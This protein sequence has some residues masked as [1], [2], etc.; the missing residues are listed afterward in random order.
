V[1]TQSISAG[2]ESG[3]EGGYDSALVSPPVCTF[4]LTRE[5]GAGS[6]GSV[7]SA[8]LTSPCAGH[9]AGTGVAV[10]YLHPELSTDERACA[11][12][13]AEARVGRTLSCRGLVT[14][15]GEGSDDRGR[16]LVME[17]VEG[18]T[19]R[20]RL[21]SEALVEE[22]DVRRI[23]RRLASVLAELHAAGFRH[24]DVKPENIRL[25]KEGEAVLLDLG[26]A[27]GEDETA[28]ARGSL[29]YL[30][31]EQ[32][33]G[34]PSTP[35]SDVFSLGLVLYELATGEHPFLYGGR[36]PTRIGPEDA[37][38]L[39]ASLRAARSDLASQR[40][41]QLSPFLDH[42]LDSLLERRPDHRPTARELEQRLEAGEAGEWWRVR[43]HLAVTQRR[44]RVDW[45]GNSF[46]PLVGRAVELEKL[47]DVAARVGAGSGTSVWLAGPPGVG[48]SRLVEEFVLRARASDRPPLHLH[49]R[50]NEWHEERPAQPVISLLRQWL[51]LP[52]RTAPGEREQA[53]LEA[54]LPP[55]TAATLASVLDPAFEGATET[56]IPHALAEWLIALG[57]EQPAIVF[58]DDIGWAGPGTIK[59]LEHIATDLGAA[60]L[61]LVFGL[62]QGSAPHHAD[63]LD[64][65]RKRFEAQGLLVA[66]Q[67]AP[68]GEAAV[69]E[70]VEEL[71]HHSVPRLPLARELWKRTRGN[72]G[73]LDELLRS[74]VSRGDAYPGPDPDQ[75]LLLRIS[76]ADLPLPKSLPK[77]I[78]ERY[79]ALPP[80]LRRWLRRL[81]IMGGRIE[82]DFLLEA[83]PETP[84][85]EIEDVLGRLVRAEWIIPVGPR[86]R[87]ARPVLR[88]AVYRSISEERRRRLHGIAARTLGA[89][90]ARRI[91][92]ASAFQRA[93]HL[94]AAGD[95]EELL[96][97]VRPLVRGLLK[98][99]HPQRVDSL[100]RWGLEAINSLPSTK[101]HESLRVQ[102]LEAAVDAADRLGKRGHQRGLLDRLS[103]LDLSQDPIAAGRVYLLHGRYA[104]STGQYGAARGMLHNALTFFERGKDETHQSEAL[105]RQALLFSHVGEMGDAARMAHRALHLATSD[106]QR[107]RSHLALAIIDLLGN[108]FAD[109]LRHSDRAQKVLRGLDAADSHGARAAA[110]LVR[111]RIYRQLGRPRRA[112]GALQRAG[113]HAQLSGERWL[114]AEVTARVGGLLLDLGRETEAEERL[115]EAL[116]LASE[117]ED[118]R[119]EALASVFL[120]TLLGEN[121]D[122]EARR[123]LERATRL[124]EE[125]GLNRLEA[126][127]LA[128]R[129]RLSRQDGDLEQALAF[130]KRATELLER[131]GAEFADRVVID[132]TRALI[133]REQGD[134]S[135]ARDLRKALERT[136]KRENERLPSV[137]LR[138]R[139]HRATSALLEASLS[140]DGP[141]YPRVRLKN[142][143][144][145]PS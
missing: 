33:R 78:A 74:L 21:L 47:L 3:R 73:L 116:L 62:R 137:L 54:M 69:F 12:F 72:S 108:H 82:T 56:S 18:P 110:L 93:F 136:L 66:L 28:E 1:K 17:L 16:H 22:A 35:A 57:H 88:D 77:L 85:A 70:L 105:R 127:G 107:A 139:H 26:F 80:E 4:E 11:A 19:L 29:A 96:K 75:G 14:V 5:L 143:P 106:K 25:D 109:A 41:P 141:V 79:R 115:R 101:E 42:I 95:H 120:G 68:L 84:R 31:P 92:A 15:L 52:R 138:Q 50:C 34:E 60:P 98:T 102:L 20:E 13:D 90:R 10:K 114:E 125:V 119:G 104:V 6:T 59:V 135:A 129:A 37:D 118:R 9:A 122:P 140:P 134:R 130:S 131:Y 117:I 51:H 44:D 30:S 23:G 113:R 124:A 63:A 89:T 39:L 81:A 55:R 121:G 7:W 83:F 8:V 49:A 38:R 126:L 132:A 100:A 67:L 142:L 145:D 27:A 32:T 144:G 2:E 87:F 61:L 97:V 76:L 128:M 65:L 94:R 86:F 46:A 112:I 103:D 43:T 58:L 99:G 36:T 45:R 64:S 40:V 48:K 111:A 133:L 123:M 24:G 91:S 71:F 53:V